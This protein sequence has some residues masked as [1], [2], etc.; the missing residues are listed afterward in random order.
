MPFPS[1][2]F[3]G[4]V[5]APYT[6]FHAD[7]SLN[8]DVIPG[9]ADF[10][11][12]RGVAGLFVCGT[13]GESASLSTEERERV[14]EAWLRATTLPVVV[15]V[16]HTSL[17]D[18]RRLAAHAGEHGAAAIAVIAPFFFKPASPEA[19]AD[20]CAAVSVA[21]P[22]L[23]LYYYHIPSM[24][25]ANLRVIDFLRAAD[26]RVPSL[27]GVKYTHEDMEDFTACLRHDQGRLDLLFGRDELLM[28]GADAGASGAVGTT[29]NYASP[30]YLRLLAALKEGDRAQ[31]RALQD[32]AIAMIA[33]CGSVGVEHLA[34]SKAL[35]AL[36]GVNCGPTRM[37][38]ANPTPT[39][40]A[41]LR[42]KL[43]AIGFFDRDFAG[44][45]S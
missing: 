41:V 15:H 35:M 3:T 24:T 13:T 42:K 14:T 44:A 38:L 18:A 4:L 34:A 30:L 6:P 36:L 31:A 5:A 2:R 32:Q 45:D 20:W 25:G 10:L 1:T 16:G 33:A 29:Y 21:A 43:S 9:Y 8:L 23:P 27:A 17:A 12:R 7:G 39:Q 22:A 26:G 11:R 37:P 28:E 19:L 40:L